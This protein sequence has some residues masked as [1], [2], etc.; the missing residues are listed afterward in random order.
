MRVSQANSKEWKTLAVPL[1][2][3]GFVDSSDPRSDPQSL[4]FFTVGLAAEALRKRLYASS[5]T[6]KPESEVMKM[7]MLSAYAETEQ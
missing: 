7:E 5:V 1:E 4:R 2:I 3:Q 6:L